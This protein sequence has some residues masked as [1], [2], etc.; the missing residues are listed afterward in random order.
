MLICKSSAI[1]IEFNMFYLR[2]LATSFSVKHLVWFSYMLSSFA[3]YC[4]I[5]LTLVKDLEEATLTHCASFNFLPTLS[6]SIAYCFPQGYIWSFCIALTSFPR[7]LVGYLQMRSRMSRSP[8]ARPKLHVS[9]E[10]ING[11]VHFLE[12]TSLLLLTFVSLREM[13]WVHICSY[14]GF[15]FF[16]ISHMFL[17]V[18][19]DY[20]WPRTIEAELTELEKRL[21]A[22]RSRLLLVNISSFSVSMCFY[23]RHLRYC[24]PMIY[25][26]HSLF[27][28]FV[29]LSNIAYHG[30]AIEEW[31][32]RGQIQIHH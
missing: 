6:A 9:V 16:S 26:I 31:N 12:L 24:E 30:L 20:A 22:K 13:Q 32:Q 10:R 21:R 8:R 4:C 11:F 23:S 28:Y 29:I 1:S 14:F 25:S 17:T 7:Y 2:L 27:E 15:V 5:G 18:G 3:F 19:I